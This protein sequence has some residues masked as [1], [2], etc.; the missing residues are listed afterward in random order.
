M[1]LGLSN[2]IQR[3]Y[4]ETEKHQA[5]FA[6][7]IPLVAPMNKSHSALPTENDIHISYQ[8]CSVYSMRDQYKWKRKMF[9]GKLQGF[10][11]QD[12]K[13]AEGNL[14]VC[15]THDMSI[16]LVKV[17]CT[18]KAMQAC[19]QF[20]WE[21]TC[22]LARMVHFPP[23]ILV[24]PGLSCARPCLFT[25]VTRASGW[26]FRVTKLHYW[27]WN[28]YI[29]R[30]IIIYNIIFLRGLTGSLDSWGETYILVPKR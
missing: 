13:L 3:I 19:H 4:S 21:R 18:K 8:I 9:Y 27:F 20:Y 25:G 16:C 5:H 23:Q 15:R 14:L 2:H 6:L 30:Q 10:L 29:K 12:C 7:A 22:F 11:Q 1:F 17:Y 26:I 28:S 24:Q